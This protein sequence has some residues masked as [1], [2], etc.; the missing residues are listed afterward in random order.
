MDIGCGAGLLS[1]QLALNGA[2]EV[3][4]IDVQEE[5]VANTLT[6]A[7]RNGVADRV[8]GKT[9]DLYTLKPKNK[10]D[11]VIA[12]LYQMPT[13]PNGKISGHRPIDYWGRN[14]LDHCITLLPKLLKDDGIAY[15]MQISLLGQQET[16]RLLREVGFQSR[17]VDYSLYQ[18]SPVFLEN[19]AQI[20]RVEQESDAYHFTFGD[21]HVMVMYLI[22]AR[23]A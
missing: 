7:F 4:A 1:I 18:F 8:I 10:I 9:T 21:S 17:I 23:R 12:S 2:T 22:E 19:M 11:V 20:E 5:A 16:E 13:N 6:N 15:I 14:I 3:T